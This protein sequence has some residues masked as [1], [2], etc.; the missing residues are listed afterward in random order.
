MAVALFMA[1]LG[2]SVAPA[3]AGPCTEQI[4]QFELAVRQSAGY[5]DAGPMDRQSIDAQIDRQPT[6]ASIKRAEQRAQANFVATLARAK[7]LDARGNRAGCTRA[8]AEAE[9]MYNLQ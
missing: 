2:L 3:Q 4:A 5:P 8:L 1:A 9:A 6:P 7:R